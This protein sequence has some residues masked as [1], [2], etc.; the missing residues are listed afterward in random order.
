[1]FNINNE[2]YRLVIIDNYCYGHDNGVIDVT[3]ILLSS[4]MTGHCCKLCISEVYK[5][6]RHT[7]NFVLKNVFFSF[8]LYSESRIGGGNLV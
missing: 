2:C 6:A 5:K 8:T 3:Q 7:V 4:F 1:M